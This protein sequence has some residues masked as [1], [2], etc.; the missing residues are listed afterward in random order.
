VDADTSSA[1]P[2]ALVAYA[3]AGLRS[4]AQLEVSA[5]R[6]AAVLDH[7]AATCREYPLG[8]DGRLATPLRD[9][10]QRNRDHNLWVRRVAEQFRLAD[11]GDLLGTD[12]SGLVMGGLEPAT[13]DSVSDWSAQQRIDYALQRMM[14]HLPAELRQQLE[15]VLTPTTLEWMVGILVVWVAGQALGY[16]EVVDVGVA[17]LGLLTL[18]PEAIRAGGEAGAF[19]TGVAGARTTDDLDTAGGHL[20]T[21][22]SIV[23]VDGLMAFLAHKAGGAAREALPPEPEPQLVG[24]TPDGLQVPVPPGDGEPPVDD[25]SLLEMA[26]GES[27]YT[28]TGKRIHKEWSDQQRA[29]GT[30]DQV[31]QPITDAS[32]DE[33]QVP[34]RVDLK[35]GQPRPNDPRTQV[36][37]PDA[38]QFDPGRIVDLKPINRPLW[39]D[40]QE[41]IRFITAFK[42]KTGRLPKEIE[43][44]RYDPATGKVV[45]I[46]TYPPE[47]FLP[48]SSAAPAEPEP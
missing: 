39:K 8:I 28:S 40:R 24:V 19:V 22:V 30:Y 3:D 43:I 41:I 35:T 7:F 18:G 36:S 48:P 38:V 33:I 9:L 42:A 13:S 12:T 20:A 14:D 4:D 34:Y 23:G 25:T 29:D 5:V 32:G 46:E 2:N 10:A 31:G 45:Q 37:I 21:V 26:S 47:Q 44:Q 27:S 16:G 6:L 11:G 1:D 17:V 15:A